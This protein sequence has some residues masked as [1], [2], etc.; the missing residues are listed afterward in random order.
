VDWNDQLR[1]SPTW[2]GEAFVISSTGLTITNL[3]RAPERI[4]MT[5]IAAV[6]P[7]FAA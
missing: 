6:S 2:L 3:H 7:E 4:Q 1:T 5:R